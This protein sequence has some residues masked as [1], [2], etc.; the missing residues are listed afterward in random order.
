MLSPRDETTRFPAL[1]LFR[2]RENDRSFDERED[3]R[4]HCCISIRSTSLHEQNIFLLLEAHWK[5]A[6]R[7]RWFTDMAR[8]LC[9]SYPIEYL[10]ALD[11]DPR[12]W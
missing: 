9:A 12:R 2:I 11:V 4:V 3:G 7:G 8:R 1:P 6:A 5:K 10:L